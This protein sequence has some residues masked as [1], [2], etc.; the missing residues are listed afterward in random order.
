[1]G[2]MLGAEWFSLYGPD[3][4][5]AFGH[6]GFTNVVAWAD[7]ERQ[8]AAAIMTSGKPLLYPELYQLYDIFRQ[9]GVACDKELGRAG[10]PAAARGI[11]SSSV[12]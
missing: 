11:Q 4:R 6:L 12:S 2:F 9:I 3:T 5:Y 8:V 10:M 7:P 1:M